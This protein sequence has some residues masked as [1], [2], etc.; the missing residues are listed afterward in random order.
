MKNDISKALI[1]DGL[2]TVVKKLEAMG[3]AYE[4]PLYDYDGKITMYT[5]KLPDKNGEEAYWKVCIKDLNS[6]ADI[7]D[8][9]IYSIRHDPDNKDLFGDQKEDMPGAV[10]C[11]AMRLFV[12]FIDILEIERKQVTV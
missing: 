3:W 7:K 8:W 4:P 2:K 9:I 10:A 1:D 6:E 11:E 12:T 5:F